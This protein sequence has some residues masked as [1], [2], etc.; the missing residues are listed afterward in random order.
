GSDRFADVDSLHHGETATTGGVVRAVVDVDRQVGHEVTR[1]RCAVVEDHVVVDALDLFAAAPHFAGRVGTP[2]RVG[3]QV[4]HAVDVTAVE[5]LGVAV[6][7]RGD[8]LAVPHAPEHTST[9]ARS[10]TPREDVDAARLQL[11]LVRRA[12][13]RALDDETDT[14]E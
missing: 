7:Q 14:L 2:R 3:E 8:L 4:H 10:S 12:L 13:D 5:Q 6:D 1:L 9:H 11:E